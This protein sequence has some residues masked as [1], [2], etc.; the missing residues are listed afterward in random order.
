MTHDGPFLFARMCGALTAWGMNIVKAGAFSNDERIVVDT[1][2]FT[3]RFQTLE[4]N[5]PEWE[6]LKGSFR[7]AAGEGGSWTECCATGSM[8]KKHS[9]EDQGGDRVEID[10]ECSKHS[11]LIEVIAQDQ[12]GLLHRIS[13][14]LARENCNI[15][16]ALI[17]TEGQTAIDVFYLTSNGAS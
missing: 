13:S 1:F 15:E 14:E 5:L 2:F 3:N 8:R 9:T 17:K 6:R 12:L 10:D 7:R 16:I 4:L 11:A